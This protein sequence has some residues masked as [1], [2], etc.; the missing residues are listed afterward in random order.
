MA[1]GDYDKIH[2]MKTNIDAGRLVIPKEIRTRAGLTPGAEVEVR[3][4]KGVVEIELAP[5][6]VRLIR[7]GLFLVATVD[8]DVPPPTA[9]EI[10]ELIDQIREERGL[11]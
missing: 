11:P 3:Y 6:K 2:G 7:E 4:N 10:D 8:T 5:G 1:S 9:E